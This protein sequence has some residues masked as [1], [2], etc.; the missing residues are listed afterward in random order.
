MDYE[1]QW[2][3]MVTYFLKQEADDIP[4]ELWQVQTT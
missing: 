4:Q 2:K 3:K 1:N